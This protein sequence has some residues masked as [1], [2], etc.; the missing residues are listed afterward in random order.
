M[1]KIQQTSGLCWHIVYNR[2]LYFFLRHHEKKFLPSDD[3]NICNVTTSMWF[4][5][6]EPVFGKYHIHNASGAEIKLI[7][8]IRHRLFSLYFL[9]KC[10]AVFKRIRIVLAE[11]VSKLEWNEIRV[12]T[13]PLL[14]ANRISRFSSFFCSPWIIDARTT[15]SKST[16]Q[17]KMSDLTNETGSDVDGKL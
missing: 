8:V 10:W 4:H 17:S 2:L 11:L 1:Y 13:R 14:N 6:G 7:L 12:G 15:R 9:V 3:Q 16:N 5:N